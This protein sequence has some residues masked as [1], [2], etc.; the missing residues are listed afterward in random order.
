M[1]FEGRKK[2][3]CLVKFL[4][5]RFFDILTKFFLSQINWIG[6]IIE[7]QSCKLLI[8]SIRCKRAVEGRHLSKIKKV[9]CNTKRIY[10]SKHHRLFSEPVLPSMIWWRPF[11]LSSKMTRGAILLMIGNLGAYNWSSLVTRIDTISV[12]VFNFWALVLDSQGVFSAIL[13]CYVGWIEAIEHIG[14]DRISF[15][16]C[17]SSSKVELFFLQNAPAYRSASSSITTTS[18]WPAGAESRPTWTAA[19]TS[20]SG[21]R[22][23]RNTGETW[24]GLKLFGTAP[25]VWQ[26][27]CQRTHFGPIEQN[28][29]NWCLRPLKIIKTYKT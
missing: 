27:Y 25:F 11:V 24:F 3:F 20:G 17:F 29:P 21:I 8:G 22:T 6:F 12:K 23:M 2:C 18:W 19:S 5:R 1:T 13:A 7:I 10:W 26:T 9:F 28:L 15:Q 4:S 14:L 16:R